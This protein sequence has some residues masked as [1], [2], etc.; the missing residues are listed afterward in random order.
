MAQAFIDESSF[1]GEPFAVSKQVGDTVLG[2]TVNQSTT[3]LLVRVT[4]TGRDSWLAKIVQLVEDA[5]RHKAPIQVYADRVAAVFAPIVVS[6][7]AVSFVFWMIVALNADDGQEEDGVF[8]AIMTAISVVV[9][10]CPCALGLGTCCMILSTAL[11]DLSCS[12]A[13]MLIL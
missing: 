6:I 10:A 2:G 13:L 11:Y 12:F 1:S 9:V 4:A 7:A 3:V 8:V 5:Q